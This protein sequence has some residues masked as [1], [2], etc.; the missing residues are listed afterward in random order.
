[1]SLILS[2]TIAHAATVADRAACTLR[3][4]QLTS[5]LSA[6]KKKELYDLC[7]R[8]KESATSAETLRSQIATLKDKELGCY[9]ERSLWQRL[10]GPERLPTQADVDRCGAAAKAKQAE[11]DKLN[12]SLA[13]QEKDLAVAESSFRAQN[14]AA[15]A[16][17]D[18]RSRVDN[19]VNREFDTMKLSIMS[20][21]LQSADAALQLT[22]MATAID[23][24]AMGLYM[25]DRMA[26]LLNSPSFC[27]AAKA[28]PA[29]RTIK[30]SDLNGVFNSTMN[31]GVNK[32][33][34]VT[35]SAPASAKPKSTDTGK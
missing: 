20:T 19:L 7:I 11:L 8:N 35:S 14:V 15:S 23:N 5:Y 25:R 32:E 18:E 10:T 17:V 31:T 33:R 2:A 16:T 26:G 24:S 6:E 12:A 27:E 13:Q 28:C 3:G 1:M 34:E 30:G 29:A 21:R 4:N 22:K 9:Q